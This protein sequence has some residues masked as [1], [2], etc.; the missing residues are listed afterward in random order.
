MTDP[1]GLDVRTSNVQ[2]RE[3]A[4]LRILKGIHGEPKAIEIG[5]LHEVLVRFV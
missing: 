4:R 3:F 2:N 1:S 5:T